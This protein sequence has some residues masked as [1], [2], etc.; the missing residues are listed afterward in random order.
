MN[1]NSLTASM[2]VQQKQQDIKW[3]LNYHMITASILLDAASTV[4][5]L[6]E[7]QKEHSG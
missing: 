3:R 2:G 4:W 7:K 6:Y 1:K 5:T